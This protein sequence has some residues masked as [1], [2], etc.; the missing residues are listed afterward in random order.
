M[1]YLVEFG[2][3]GCALQQWRLRGG[4]CY[5]VGRNTGCSIVLS[6][7]SMSRRHALLLLKPPAA[8]ASAA[9]AAAG[10]QVELHELGAINGTVVNGKRVKGHSILPL[11]AGA[12][13]SFGENPN[14]Y[15]ILERRRHLLLLLLLL[16]LLTVHMAA[17][18]AAT[19]LSLVYIASLCYV[20]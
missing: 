1:A 8:A 16:L 4:R 17:E 20:V 6:H 15:R 10:L 13:I 3:D 12:E 18:L 2:R 14:A 11:L 7:I 19:C 9:A 5:S